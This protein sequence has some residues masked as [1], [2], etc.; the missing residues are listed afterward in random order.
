MPEKIDTCVIGGSA[1]S[2]TALK[3]ILPHLPKDLPMAI[4]VC[5]HVTSAEDGVSASLL[6]RHTELPVQVARDGMPV[7]QGQII[8]APPGMH[9]MLGSDHVHLRMGAH[10]NNFRPAIDPL[11]RSAAIYRASR[12]VGVILS[13][14]LNDGASGARAMARTGGS[15]IA[16]DPATAEFPAMPKAAMDAV[17]EAVAVSLDQIGATLID[18]AGTIAAPAPPI[19]KDIG[20]ELKIAAMEGANMETEAKLGELSPLNCPHCNGV[21]WEIKDGPLLRFRCHTGHAYTAE[22]LSEE[23]NEMLDRGLFDTL[24]A[25]RGRIHLLQRLA[26]RA[27]PRARKAFEERVSLVEEDAERLEQIIVNRAVADT[28]V[29]RPYD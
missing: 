28:G 24:R 17:P 19:P 16:Q 22:A 18:I 9:L 11:F 7:R 14:L 21:L 10:E 29:E 15:I 6:Q 5:R 23:Q 3:Q 12:A 2:L 26:K 25:H 8:V 13:G 27:E 4:L 1:G 20:I